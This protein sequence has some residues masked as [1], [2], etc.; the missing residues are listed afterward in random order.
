VLIL[1][2]HLAEA[3]P[4]QSQ[5]ETAAEREAREQE[6]ARQAAVA[7]EIARREAEAA[8]RKAEARARRQAVEGPQSVGA[9]PGRAQGAPQLQP[10]RPQGPP[11]RPADAAAPAEPT[12]PAGVPDGGATVHGREPAAGRDNERVAETESRGASPA[13]KAGEHVRRAGD[14]RPPSAER[15]VTGARARPAEGPMALAFRLAQEKKK[16]AE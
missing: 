6:E 14:P 12:A 10:R 7:A 13:D 5:H 9:G 2:V 11:G 3:H 15:G 4:E 8:Q 1:A 16:Q